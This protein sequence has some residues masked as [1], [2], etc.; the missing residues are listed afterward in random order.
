SPRELQRLVEQIL[1]T[2]RATQIVAHPALDI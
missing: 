1:E 2:G